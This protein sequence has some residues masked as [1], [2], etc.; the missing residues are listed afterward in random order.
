MQFIT[1]ITAGW[2]WNMIIKSHYADWFRAIIW[3]LEF[4]HFS[5]KQARYDARSA[6]KQILENAIRFPDQ[7]ERIFDTREKIA[8]AIEKL[9]STKPNQ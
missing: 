1:M 5:G 9:I 4:N 3:R 6:K 7:R 2:T 8:L